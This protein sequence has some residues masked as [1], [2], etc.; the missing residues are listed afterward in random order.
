MRGKNTQFTAWLEHTESLVVGSWFVHSSIGLSLQLKSKL[1]KW[2]FY[3]PAVRFTA[4]SAWTKFVRTLAFNRVVFGQCYPFLEHYIHPRDKSKNV[5]NKKMFVPLLIL[6][7]NVFWDNKS[8]LPKRL[9][10]VIQ[11]W[12]LTCLSK[13]FMAKQTQHH[14]AG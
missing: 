9:N 11:D 4:W 7:Y 2:W 12:S 13:H 6:K 1:Q 5:L 8:F 10:H 3:K 14:K